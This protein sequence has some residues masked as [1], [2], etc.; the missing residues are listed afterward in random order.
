MLTLFLCI[1][2][3]L[4]IF[5]VFMDAT[6]LFKLD[7]LTWT[8]EAKGP[9]INQPVDLEVLW[10]ILLTTLILNILKELIIMTVNRLDS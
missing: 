1:R 10:Q 8:S 4:N 7:S 6:T 5:M 2:P 3:C 9:E